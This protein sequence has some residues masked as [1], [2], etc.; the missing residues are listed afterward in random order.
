MMP[1]WTVDDAGQF[2]RRHEGLTSSAL[3]AVGWRVM[4]AVYITRPGGPEVLELRELPDPLP[5]P[6]QVRVAVRAAGVQP[7][8]LAIREG[9]RPGYAPGGLAP[10]PGNEFAGVIDV[11]GPD[12]DRWRVGDEV[13]GFTF[14]GCAAEQLVV[15]AGQVVAKPAS[16][17]WE[18]AGGFTAGAQTAEM[19][20]E[21]VEPRPGD[22]VLVHGAAGNVGGYAVQLARL[23]GARVIGTA[24]SEH[25]AYLRELGAEAIDYRGDV[26][27]AVQATAP[28]GVDVALDCAGRGA[29]DLFDAVVHDLGRTRTIYEHE[30]GP[31]RGVA[32]L[33]GARS[34]ERL[35]RLVGLA[36]AGQLQTLIRSTYPFER[37]ADA[38]RELGSG[39]GRGKIV[40]TVG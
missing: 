37:A 11:V 38:H 29:L 30:A 6:G 9:F 22:V 23:R 14:M 16:M 15:D 19:A 40:L 32:T 27:A 24:R 21:E 5:A 7:L 35:E 1:R 17:P 13:L 12:V 28:E 20:W 4:R 8:D 33:S 39:H 3:D 2:A 26:V 25:H 31:A 10:I 36:S 34:A 18:V